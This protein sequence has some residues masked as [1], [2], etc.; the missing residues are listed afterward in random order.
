MVSDLVVLPVLLVTL[1]SVGVY[2]GWKRRGIH[3]RMAD[4]ASRPVAELSSPGVVEVEGTAVP[5][6]APVA[7]PVTGRDAVVAAWTVEEWDERG[8]TSRWR[9][10]AR[11]IEAPAFE[12]DD[13][14]GAVAAGPISTRDTAGKWTQTAGVSATNGVRIDGVLAEFESFATRTERP[15]DEEPPDRIR[16]L[17]E[18][19]GLYGD[20]GSITNAVDVGKKHGR[21]RYAEGIVEPGEEAYLLGRVEARDDPTAERFRPG[22]AVVTEPPDGPLVVSDREGE[23]LEAAFESSVRTRLVAGAAATVVGLAGVAYVLLPV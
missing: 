7:A 13:G 18:D 16:R 1:G 6:E 10:V 2:T 11:G 21:R 12:V 14:T 5:V 15:P 8:D 22:E 9:E 3:A 4:A 23:R 20:V 17:H 19:H